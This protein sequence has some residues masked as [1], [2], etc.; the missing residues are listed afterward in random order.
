[1]VEV[2][3]PLLPKID[4][5]LASIRQLVQMLAA[6]TDLMLDN[7]RLSN[8]APIRSGCYLIPP[9][10]LIAISLHRSPGFE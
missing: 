3:D 7:A 10:N 6:S 4:I 9:I 1:M 2:I 8:E 5:I